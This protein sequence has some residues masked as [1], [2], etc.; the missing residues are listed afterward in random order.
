MSSVVYALP[1]GC[2]APALEIRASTAADEQCVACKRC[3][4]DLVNEG[5]ATGR[6]PRCGKHLEGKR[7]R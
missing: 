4:D 1:E 7:W 2:G 3:A 5:D 6:V